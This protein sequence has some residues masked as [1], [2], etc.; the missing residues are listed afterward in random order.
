[1]RLRDLH[2]RALA[3]KQTGKLEPPISSPESVLSEG[4]KI[5]PF[6]PRPLDQEENPDFW[7]AWSSLFDWLKEHASERFDAICEAETAIQVLEQTGVT[8]GQDYD[9]AC[10]ELLWQFEEARRLCMATRL[11]VWV[12]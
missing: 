11:K 2:A 1:M 10:A 4:E 6:L 9:Q 7:A 3:K 8:S 5:R 12:Q